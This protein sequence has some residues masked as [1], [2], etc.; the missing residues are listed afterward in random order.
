[1]VG[2]DR[3]LGML[4]EA[5]V[6]PPAV[7]IVEG[8]AGVGK[9]RLIEEALARPEL[10]DRGRYMGRCHHLSEPFPLG[11]VVEAL[12]AARPPPGSLSAVAGAL[13]PVL[14]ELAQW[15]P[16]PPP[17]LGDVAAERHRRF[18]A[19]RELLAALGA[20]VL[21]LEDLHWADRATLELLRFLVVERPPELVVVCTYRREG[22]AGEAL[23]AGLTA[24]LPRGT[25]AVCVVLEPLDRRQV[26]ELVATI[27]QAD[28]VSEEFADHLFERTA[29]LPFAV[30]EVLLL[31]EQRR[32]LIRRTGRWVR[33]DLER[34]GVPGALRDSILERLSR[35]GP[36]ARRS[37]QAAAVIGRPAA[38]R[39][40]LDVAE[41]ADTALADALGSALLVEKADGRYGFRHPLAGEAVEDAIPSP[42]RRRLHV[43][44]AHAIE[45]TEPKPLAQLAHHLRQADSPEWIRYAEAAADRASSL[46]DDAT[47]YRFL[48]AALDVSDLAPATRGRLAAKLAGLALR[49][50][51]HEEAIGILERELDGAALEGA[52]RGEVRLWLGRL[53]CQAGAFPA[54][55]AQIER[56]IDELAPRPDLAAVAMVLLAFPEGAG[57]RESRHWLDRALETA[58]GAGDR[59]LTISVGADRA[60]M[61]LLIGEPPGWDAM[62]E[63]PAPGAAPDEI[64]QAARASLNLANSL[65]H[66]GYHGRARELLHEG[67]TLATKVGYTAA[68]ANL[69][70]TRLQL[71]WLTGAWD[72]LEA[73]IRVCLDAGEHWPQIRMLGELLLASLSLARGRVR[74][75]VRLLA[76][77]ADGLQS[78]D[79]PARDAALARIRLAEGSTDAALAAAARGLDVVR[80]RGGWPWATDVAPVAV[81][82]LLAAGRREQAVALTGEL[83]DGLRG[84]DAPAASAA[85]TVCRALLDEAGSEHE[86]AGTAYLAAD[87][88]WQALPRPYEAARA[89][90]GAGRCL[91]RQDR[92]R[93][94]ALLLDALDAFRG[95]GAAWD[96]ARARGTLREQGMMPRHR[97]GRRG[98]GDRLSPRERQVARS[99]R[100][101]LTN[102]EIALELYLSPRTVEHHLRAAMRKLGVSSRAE[103]ADRLP[104]ID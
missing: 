9:T 79:V 20:T 40:L 72:G 71:D 88:A 10:H 47:A 17:P 81:E 38:E 23:P 1:M 22:R 60:A 21:V 39:V 99:A 92:E 74:D 48:K 69:S 59:A 73:Q 63:I 87:A 100:A 82:A 45:N 8:E 7:V 11:P 24:R 29:G 14:P 28:D 85:L 5:A 2:R 57:A 43:R 49:S 25:A 3:E 50:A 35:L 68:S 84:R 89:R 53:L 12:R 19:L 75:A 62:R 37:V 65:L 18:R 34:L 26:R 67:L 42:L 30:E 41:V 56:A 80:D 52:L 58:A 31:L 54:G 64:R 104:A 51:E 94:Q 98:Y 32:D 95:L 103:L 66:L 13:R 70:L 61:M 27:L 33:R 44:A 86:R 83:A 90:E 93:G 36:A 4:L 97:R 96:A 102:R 46:E 16:P 77:P 6:R 101:G 55:Y 15:L 78:E 76:T 91:L